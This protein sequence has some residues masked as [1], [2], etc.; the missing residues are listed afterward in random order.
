MDDGN[1]ED[2]GVKVRCCFTDT[3]EE[4]KEKVRKGCNIE[5]GKDFELIEAQRMRS[6]YCQLLNPLSKMQ[7]VNS[8]VYHNYNKYGRF[9]QP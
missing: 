6:T 2:Q 3:V 5:E 9:F 7:P 4:I 1:Y 8:G